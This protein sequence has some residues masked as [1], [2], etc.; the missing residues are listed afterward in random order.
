MITLREAK[1]SIDNMIEPARKRRAMKWRE[2]AA[3]KEGQIQILKAAR[4]KD[5]SAIDYLFLESASQT[6]VRRT[7]ESFERPQLWAFTLI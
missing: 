3:T 4:N 2:K 6:K 5:D 7:V 1:L